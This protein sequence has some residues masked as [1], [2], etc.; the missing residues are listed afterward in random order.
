VTLNAMKIQKKQFILALSIGIAVIIILSQI[1]SESLS[2]GQNFIEVLPIP[3]SEG[4][5]NFEYALENVVLENVMDTITYSSLATATSKGDST[6]TTGFTPDSQRMFEEAQI[7][8]GRAPVGIS[9]NPTTGRLYVA[10]FGSNTISVINSTDQTEDIIEVLALPYSV[11]VN[12][13]SRG[14]YVANLASDTISVIEGRTNRLVANIENITTPVSMDFNLGSSWL[15]VTSIDTDTISKIDLVTNRI[16]DII[17]VGKAPYGIAYHPKTQ[18]IYVSNLG[19]NSVSVLESGEK[20]GEN[21]LVANITVG[22]RPSY[23]TINPNND[24]VYVSNTFSDTI[25]VINGTSLEV[26]AN[27]P[28][29]TQPVGI[30]V[31]K[32]RN[33]IYVSNTLSSTVSVIDGLSNKVIKRVI[34]PSNFAPLMTPYDEIPPELEFPN[35]AS[36]I[37]IDPSTRNAYVSHTITDTISVIDIDSLLVGVRFNVDPPSSGYISCDKSGIAYDD[38]Y[39]R[40][41]YDGVMKCEAKAG[42]G[43]TFNSWFGSTPSYLINSSRIF[44]SIFDYF[45]QNDAKRQFKFREYG[46]L[47]ANFISA[48]QFP[49]PEEYLIPLYGVIPGF[50]IPSIIRWLNGKRQRGLMGKYRKTVDEIYNKLYDKREQCLQ[51]FDKIKSQIIFEYEKGRISE[52]HYKMLKERI[53]EYVQKVNGHNE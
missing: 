1:M 21:K 20:P 18:R 35:V 36:F 9:I 10:N 33:L 39:K 24:L 50:F 43:F 26:I 32:S 40:V 3:L 17:K 5:G 7:E 12:P 14:I 23:I 47:T 16:V 13:F 38:N 6:A 48:P 53:S 11:A 27:I 41:P 52:S 22:D 42:S 19:S 49:I 28:T 25:S 37:T 29:D 31:D 2:S 15:Y 45:A 44:N 34:L 4:F 8:V 46:V 51:A 30:A